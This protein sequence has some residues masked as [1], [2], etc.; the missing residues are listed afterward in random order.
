MVFYVILPSAVMLV[1][2]LIIITRIFS[3]NRR[4]RHL[5][6]LSQKRFA[7]NKQVSYLLLL[8]NILFLIMVSPLLVANSMSL[9]TD[10]QPLLNTVVYLL[11]YSNHGFFFL[12]LFPLKT[13]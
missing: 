3:V 2:S 11:A 13:T 10:E 4:L 9:L 6:G 12:K 7:R 5:K 1:C 8:T